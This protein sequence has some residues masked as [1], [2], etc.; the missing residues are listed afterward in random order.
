[1]A[2]SA[3][4]AAYLAGLLGGVHCLAMC[5]GFALALGSARFS[6]RLQ[7]A[8]SLALSAL[9]LNAGRVMTYALLGALVGGV[10]SGLLLAAQSLTVQRA[11]YVIANLMLIAVAVTLV[12]RRE[13]QGLLQRVAG[14]AFIALGL[15][16]GM[17]S[18]RSGSRHAAESCRG[19]VG[20]RHVRGD[21]RGARARRFQLAGEEPVLFRVLTRCCRMPQ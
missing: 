21:R 3:L 8:R 5:G 6:A 1:M 10:A 15:T 20:A 4:I 13:R 14:R 9:A 2:W 19:C 16:M 11:L 7:P 18:R 17:L 12:S